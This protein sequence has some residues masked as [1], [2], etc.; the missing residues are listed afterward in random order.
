VSL[1]AELFDDADDVRKTYWQD[2]GFVLMEK[3]TLFNERHFLELDLIKQRDLCPPQ[4]SQFVQWTVT[5]GLHGWVRFPLK[6]WTVLRG[7]SPT[8]WDKFIG[9]ETLNEKASFLFPFLWF[10]EVSGELT[11]ADLSAYSAWLELMDQA[12]QK[13]QSTYGNYPTYDSF[14]SEIIRTRAE[15]LMHVLIPPVHVCQS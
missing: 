3:L 9:F 11:D 2:H 13:R 6:V 7:L 4:G 12:L 5:L 15:S 8:D 10:L 14:W 1:A